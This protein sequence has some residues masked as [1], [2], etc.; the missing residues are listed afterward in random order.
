MSVRILIVDDNP[1]ITELVKYAISLYD[2]EQI[3]IVEVFVAYD[4]RLGLE[5]ILQYKPDLII[6]DVKMPR[7]DGYQ[8]AH[9]IRADTR[10]GDTPIIILSA[11]TREE[12]EVMGLRSGADCY[13][14]KPFKPGRLNAYINAMLRRGKERYKADVKG[15]LRYAG[16]EV[17]RNIRQAY[18]GHNT[19]N[20]TTKEFELL[21]F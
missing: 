8:L 4:G 10:V 9:C 20:L 11:M 6:L 17:D 18:R 12:D 13:L 14:T 2:R 1:T 7:L 19:L 3:E 21:L 5:C 15:V 16:I